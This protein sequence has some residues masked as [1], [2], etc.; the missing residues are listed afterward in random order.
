MKIDIKEA[1]K[2]LEEKLKN[3]PNNQRIHIDKEI[4]E[5]LLFETIVLDE[6]NNIIMKYPIWSGDFLSKIDLSELTFEDVAWSDLEFMYSYCED[7]YNYYDDTQYENLI[8]TLRKTIEKY[9]NRKLNYSNTNAKIDFKK[10]AEYKIYDEVAIDS[11]NFSGTDLSNFDFNCKYSF[12]RSNLT[13]TGFPLER[14][15]KEELLNREASFFTVDLSNIDLSS[16]E[17][18]AKTLSCENG[19]FEICPTCNLTN[20]GLKIRYKECK[21]QLRKLERKV[22]AKMISDDLLAGCY[23][24]DHLISSKEQLK[25]KKEKLIILN[26]KIFNNIN[27]FTTS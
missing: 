23:I 27:I 7:E 14:I 25:T 3:V 26:F 18:S 15:L 2:I 9:R 5:K 17:I 22:L 11:I 16:I 12:T 10:S 20:T 13:N 24:D 21:N 6:E 1:K 4:L 19:K 8:N